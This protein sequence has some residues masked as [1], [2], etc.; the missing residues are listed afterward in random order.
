MD[1]MGTVNAVILTFGVSQK[2]YMNLSHWK[3]IVL[4][5]HIAQGTRL[6][7]TWQPGEEGS[8]GV[9]G[10]MAESLHCSLEIITT[11][12]TGYV[13]VQSLSWVRL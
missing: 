8:L 10:H 4:S 11:L 1:V 3:R 12:L 9:N 5:Y 6:S 13:V 2:T 7:V